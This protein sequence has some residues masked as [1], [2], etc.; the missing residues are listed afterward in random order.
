MVETSKSGKI[1][2][3]FVDD[4]E[5]FLELAESYFQKEENKIDPVFT[6][7][8][9]EAL[10]LLEEDAFE[11]IV[12]DYDMPEMDGLEFLEKLRSDGNDIPF[13]FL[14]GQGKEKVAMQ[15]LN[16][17]AD[18]YH[19]KDRGINEQFGK[20]TRS[21]VEETIREKSE[22]ELETFQTWIKNTLRD[23]SE[24]SDIP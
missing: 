22:T 16:K 14:T 3:L 9:Q 15:A 24:K 21:I 1:K 6:T 4:E 5:D 8:A 12:S 19:R 20:L 13:I 17:G 10:E 18:R 23:E 7:S 2:I 11:A